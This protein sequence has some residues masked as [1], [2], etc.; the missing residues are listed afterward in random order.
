MIWIACALLALLALA[1][2]LAWLLPQRIVEDCGGCEE[3]KYR[4]MK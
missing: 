1:P 2:L 3:C 4:R